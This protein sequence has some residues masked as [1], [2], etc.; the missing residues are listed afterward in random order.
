MMFYKSF[1][2]LAI[3]F[4]AASN[5]AAS[6]APRCGPDGCYPAPSASCNTGPIQ[7]CNQ[8]ASANDEKVKS[9]PDELLEIALHAQIPVAAGC[10]NVI[11]ETKW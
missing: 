6:V 7:C 8:W 1:V 3:A 11:G 9:L 5:V 10:V 4:A 2:S